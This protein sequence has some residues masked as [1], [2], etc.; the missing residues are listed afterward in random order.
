MRWKAGP[1][2][3][4][5][6][7]PAWC[8]LLAG[9][10]LALLSAPILKAPPPSLSFAHAFLFGAWG[11][12]I[13]VLFVLTRYAGRGPPAVRDKQLADHPEHRLE[14][15]PPDQLDAQEH[16]YEDGPRGP[17]EEELQTQCKDEPESGQDDKGGPSD[18]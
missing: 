10:A 2:E 6:Q 12:V 13:L 1:V 5:L 7:R 9:A 15:Q 17:L 18:A 4:T 3:P 8:F 16:R 11:L 14:D